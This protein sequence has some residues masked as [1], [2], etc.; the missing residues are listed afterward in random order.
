M[1]YFY[2]FIVP[3]VVMHVIVVFNPLKANHE[4][5]N[6]AQSQKEV[7][8]YFTNTQILHFS[9]ARQNSK[10]FYYHSS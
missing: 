9:F 8:A 1:I 5:N 4:Y 2:Q 3:F 10:P 7:F 6:V